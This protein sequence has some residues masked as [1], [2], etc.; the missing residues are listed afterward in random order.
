MLILLAAQRHDMTM[1]NTKCHAGCAALHHNGH[2]VRPIEDP[3]QW[4]GLHRYC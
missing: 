4:S 1:S 2:A 3:L